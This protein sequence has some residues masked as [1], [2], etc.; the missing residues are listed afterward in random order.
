MVM[1]HSVAPTGTENVASYLNL[2]DSVFVWDRANEPI[3]NWVGDKENYKPKF[4]ESKFD[5][6]KKHPSQFEVQ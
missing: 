5:F 4:I 2:D 6:F 3:Y 1:L